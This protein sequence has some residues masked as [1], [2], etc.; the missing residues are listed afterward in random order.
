[1]RRS[2]PVNKQ[3]E[4]EATKVIEI[5]VKALGY[6]ND[7]DS[8]VRTLWLTRYVAQQLWAKLGNELRSNK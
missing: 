8:D 2:I 1:M 3:T 6:E 5:S 4:A 7:I